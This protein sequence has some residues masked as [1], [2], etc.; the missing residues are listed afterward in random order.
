MSQGAQGSKSHIIPQPLLCIS[1]MRRKEWRCVCEGENCKQRRAKKYEEER[2]NE[3]RDV[4]RRGQ[5]RRKRWKE[6]TEERRE[7]GRGRR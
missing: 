1:R 7:G 5:R 4:E 2:K 3:R 6:E